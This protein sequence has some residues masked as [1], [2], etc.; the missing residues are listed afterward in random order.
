M[1]RSDLD[2]PADPF[3]GE[4]LCKICDATMTYNWLVKNWECSQEHRHY[5]DENSLTADHRRRIIEALQETQGKLDKE[6]AYMPEHRHEKI[7][8]E[9]RDH[10]EK[11][12]RMLK[13]GTK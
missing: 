11:L 2:P 10:I 5:H 4:R 1:N 9:Y 8:Q 3:G 13:G 6:M 12:N 7:T